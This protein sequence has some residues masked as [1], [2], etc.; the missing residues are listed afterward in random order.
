MGGERKVELK[1]V[2]I[3][4]GWGVKWHEALV[5]ETNTRRVVRK[6]E[7]GNRGGL[8]ESERKER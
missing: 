7:L 5:G 8:G 6:E 3:S 4:K 2:L 1:Y